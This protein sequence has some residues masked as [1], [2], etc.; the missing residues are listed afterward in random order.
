[1]N[2]ILLDKVENLGDI[3]DLVSVQPGYGRNFLIPQ[4]KAALA[5]RANM[6]EV[7]A[8]RAE[9]EKRV[10]EETA[11]A[12]ARAELISGMD[13][14]IT[15]NDSLPASAQM[16]TF[17]LFAVTPIGI[18]LVLIQ[19]YIQRLFL[20]LRKL[21]VQLAALSDHV[22]SSYRGIAAIQGFVEGQELQSRKQP[23]PSLWCLLKSP[24]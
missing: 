1:M 4:G 17:G 3:G 15:A 7:E 23:V 14:I 24:S 21:Q 19:A 22:L 9:L 20:L 13:L 5:T 6:E 2:V 18:A 8:R 16:E 11:A 10:A 12:K